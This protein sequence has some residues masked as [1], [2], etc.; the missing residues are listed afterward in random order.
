M[1]VYGCTNPIALNYDFSNT[2]DG[3]CQIEGC[4]DSTAFNFDPIANID[5]G[6]CIDII[7]G[8]IDSNANNFD[9]SANT[10]DGSCYYCAIQ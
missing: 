9:S 10:D 3:T 2:D 7:L 8:C 6:S 1:Y 4:T 5:N